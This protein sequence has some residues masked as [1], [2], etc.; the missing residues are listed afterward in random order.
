MINESFNYLLDEYFF[1]ENGYFTNT[2][3]TTINVTN[4]NLFE[5]LDEN[6]TIC[7]IGDSI[8][9]GTKNNFHPWYEALDLVARKINISKGGAT[10][11][12]I[13][14]LL[15]QTDG[16]NSYK[17]Y[18]IAIGT[19]DI[20]YN[21]Y[22]PEEYVDNIEEI[23][24]FLGKDKNYIILSPWW[25]L[26]GDYNCQIDDLNKEQIYN[27]YINAL[28]NLCDS[29]LYTFVDVTNPTIEFLKENDE[30]LYF[31][32]GVHINSRKGIELYS[33]IFIENLP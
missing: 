23:I 29:K 17:N 13:L 5:Y 31:I 33:R 16:S 3:N 1:N 24:S 14:A 28:K 7:F 19:N 4:S 8:T 20:R 15:K 25:S 21:T 11:K 9:E 30:H 26:K 2:S 12:D 18:I 27:E 22:T 32:D 10:S 6:E